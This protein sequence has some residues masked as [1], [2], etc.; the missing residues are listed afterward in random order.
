M[1]LDRDRSSIR[2]DEL[3][4]KAWHELQTSRT[5]QEQYSI[6]SQHLIVSTCTDVGS[7][8]KQD[9]SEIRFSSCGY[10]RFSAGRS[11]MVSW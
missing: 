5:Q 3:Q 4:V 11:P 9:D 7:I 10:R 1:I 8:S 2:D 6:G